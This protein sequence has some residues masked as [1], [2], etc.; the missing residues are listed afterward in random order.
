[1]SEFEKYES[2]DTDGIFSK[3]LRAGRRTYFFDVRETKAGDYYLTITESKKNTLDD[4]NIQYK[5]HKIYLYKEDFTNFK[6]L[7]NE[8]TAYILKE[9]GEVV[10]SE[11]HQNDFNP[12]KEFSNDQSN[13]VTNDFTDLEFEDI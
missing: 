13:G 2:V 12:K 3:V 11:K 10:I 5:K 6:E 9:K 7:L 8:T 1:M 4:G